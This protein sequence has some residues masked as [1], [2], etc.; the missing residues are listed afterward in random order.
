[1][2]AALETGSPGGESSQP[3]EAACRTISPF[4]DRP[5]TPLP[6]V[7]SWLTGVSSLPIAIDHSQQ[8]GESGITET[9]TE[10]QLV[11]IAGFICSSAL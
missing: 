2:A 8:A 9:L 1:V 4:G 5:A 7:R 10:K 6:V 3:G 11:A